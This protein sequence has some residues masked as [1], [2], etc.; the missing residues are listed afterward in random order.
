M[1]DRLDRDARSPSGDEAF[2]DEEC[3]AVSR[4]GGSAAE[5]QERAQSRHRLTRSE[6]FP[7]WSPP[8]LCWRTPDGSRVYTAAN[9]GIWR[10]RNDSNVR[11]SDS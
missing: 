3:T 2:V 9:G 4:N 5:W 8:A 1:L 10:A 6:H 7:H 11:P